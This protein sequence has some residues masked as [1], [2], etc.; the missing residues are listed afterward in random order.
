M[1]ATKDIYD[2]IIVGGG[3]AGLTAAVWLRRHRR[4]VLVI[5]S[6]PVRN[7]Q[8]RAIHGF[9]GYDGC[10]P[11]ELLGDLRREA[12]RY[13]TEIL[14]DWVDDV[15]PGDGFTVSTKGSGSFRCRR[16]LLATGTQDVKPDIPGFDTYAGQ[17]AWHCPSCDGYEYTGKKLAIVSWGPHMAGYAREF[18]AYTRNI[19]IVTHGHPPEASKRELAAVKAQG[20]HIRQDRIRAIEGRDGSMTGLR[21]EDGSLLPCEGLFYSIAHRPRLELM[22]KLGCHLEQGGRATCIDRKQHTTIRGVY[23]AGDVA[24]LEEFV[25]V[26]AA[27]GAVSAHNMHESLLKEDLD[28]SGNVPQVVGHAVDA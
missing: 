28:R 25:V 16:L 10:D 8:A 5:T 27:M 18:L 9:P 7:H 13:R 15:S 26:A 19:T 14:E 12:D 1:N 23:V 11:A 22:R 3:F 21:L 6:G 17:S 4:H 20:I 24:P 2:V